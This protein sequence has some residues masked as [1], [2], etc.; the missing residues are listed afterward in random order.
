MPCPRNADLT[1]LQRRGRR[2]IATVRIK[3]V[4]V[5]KQ[6][7]DRANLVTGVYWEYDSQHTDLLIRSARDLR[8]P[9]RGGQ[10][11]ARIRFN[12]ISESSVVFPGA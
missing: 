9:Q 10:E 3:R 12:T 7:P 8:F 2:L 11:R 1:L 6:A 5:A 4:F